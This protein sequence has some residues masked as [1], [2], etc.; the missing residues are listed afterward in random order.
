M[1]QQL[2]E[3][4]THAVERIHNALK[5]TTDANK[6]QNRLNGYPWTLAPMTVLHAHTGDQKYLTWA[7]EGLVW[8]VD[9]AI[10]NDGSI[11]P[12]LSSF[13]LMQPFCEAFLY[14]QQQNALTPEETQRIQTQVGISADTHLDSTDWGGQ[15]RATVDA[16]GFY[17]AA[18][19][20]PHHPNATRWRHYGDALINDSWGRWSIEDASIYGP[21]WLFYL[22]TT[23]DLNK[24]SDEFMNFVTTRYYFEFY[25]G[26]ITP[27]GMLPE[28]GDGDWTHMWHWYMAT[29]VRAGS[30][31][32][33]G[34]Y[35]YFAK[36][37][38]DTHREMGLKEP[39]HGFLPTGLEEGDGLYCAATAL[40]WL[41]TSI[42]IKPYTLPKSEELVDDLVSKKII[43]RNDNGT[44]SS[45]AFLNYRDQGPYGR[46]QRDYQNQQ[47]AAYEEKPHHGHG[48]ENA[49]NLLMDHETVLL[50]DGGYR[51]TPHDGWRADL[52]HN[53]IVARLGWPIDHN[54]MGYLQQNRSYSPIQTEKIHFGN[55]DAIDYSR[56]R[57]I[58][59][60][61]GYTTDR[62]ILFLVK[63][64]VYIIVDAIHI[65]REGHKLFTNM[66]HPSHI[67]EQSDFAT[68][69]G[70]WMR[71]WPPKIPVRQDNW[72][73]PHHKE[74]LIEFFDNRDKYTQVREI[75]RCYNPSQAFFQFLY[76]HFFKGQRLAFVT[77]LTP[78]TTGQFD[79]S[80]LGTVQVIH[81]PE[82]S[83]RTLGLR[84]DLEGSPV[85]VGLKLDQT[86][87][88][89]NL[90][91]RPMFDWK[92]GQV[93]YGD[94]QTDADFAFVRDRGKESDIGF[95][96]GSQLTYKNKTLFDMPINQHMYQGSVEEYRVPDIKDKMPRWC[97]TVV[98]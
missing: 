31:Y 60:E 17:F 24:R 47:L 1:Q 12:L 34:E 87:G 75:D 64:G 95:I 42:P 19:A 54:V 43:F 96:Y 86:I 10:N 91:G 13:R 97:E 45:Y 63:T 85:T 20:V 98:I 50:A 27:N 35:L 59:D 55:F 53:K 2:L 41:D 73:N 83:Y 89:T 74:L 7:H 57:L 82:R 11:R 58:D 76:S 21:F 36:R 40:R 93:T 65:D 56:T 94:L 66:W 72:T 30:E 67:I 18:V 6:R 37:L 92:T 33:N 68:E 46:Y 61:R 4:V 44:K 38:Y 29:M 90:R 51:R 16:A 3:D 80:M 8:M 70:H 81:D 22:M 23:A 32:K 28:W 5:A 78:H 69:N 71:S 39:I 48:D 49:I 84:F 9:S 25:R 26:L 79:K 77:V 52:Y 15:N 88:L 14:L 62:I